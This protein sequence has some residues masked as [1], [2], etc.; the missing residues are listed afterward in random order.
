MNVVVNNNL[1]GAGVSCADFDLDGWEDL[2]VA[3][4]TSQVFYRNVYGTPQLLTSP[5]SADVKPKHPV[6]VDYDN[7][8]DLDYYFSQYMHPC[9]LFRNEGNW[10]FTDVSVAAGIEPNPVPHF[11][12]SWGDYDRDGDLDLFQCT[13][14]FIYTGQNPQAYYNK[15]YRNNGDGT[16]SE[17]GESAGVSDGISLSFQS[18]WMDYNNDGWPDLYVINDKF[19]PNRLYHNNGNGTFTDVGASSGAAVAEIDAMT[20]SAADYNGDGWEDIFITNTSIGACAL[21]TNNGDGTFTDDAASS[22]LE[23]DI[24][25]WAGNWFDFDLDMDQDLYVCE[26]NPLQPSTPNKFM[27]NM[28][29]GTFYNLQNFIFPLDFTNSYASASCDWNHDGYPDLAVNNYFPHASYF[30]KNSGGDHH[31]LQ[32]GLEGVVSNRMGVGARLALHAGGVTQHRYV[33]CGENYLGQNSQYELFGTGDE[34]VVD[35]L[36]VHWPSGHTDRFDGIATDQHVTVVE[37]SGFSAAIA[38]PD[39]L[40]LCEGDSLLL[41]TAVAGN[42]TWSNGGNTPAIWVTEAGQYWLTVISPLGFVSDSAFVEVIPADGQAMLITAIPETCHNASDGFIVLESDAEVTALLN[43]DPFTGE[44]LGLSHGDYALEVWDANGCLHHYAIVLEEASALFAEFSVSPVLCHGTATGQVEIVATNAGEFQLLWDGNWEDQV[45]NPLASGSYDWQLLTPGG[46][47][48]TGM[49]TVPEPD[50]LSLAADVVGVSCQGA[51]D[52]IVSLVAEGGTA[53]YTFS[54]APM[55]GLSAGQYTYNVVDVNGCTAALDV[56]ISEPSLLE[57]SIN[58]DGCNSWFVT[59]SGGTAPYTYQWTDAEGNI[60]S[61]NAYLEGI[62][63]WYELQLVVE[64]ARGCVEVSP[65]L[66]CL[67]VDEQRIGGLLYP[68]PATTWLRVPDDCGSGP[69]TVLDMSGR[70]LGQCRWEAETLLL[71]ILTDGLYAV[72]CAGGRSYFFMVTQ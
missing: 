43:G 56:S 33:Y 46:C 23:L 1:Y 4:D 35:S 59:V 71:P 65:W 50:A 17:V 20:A 11:G 9:K 36:I 58:T 25:G 3:L 30:W 67:S 7:D 69:W 19:H 16:F 32:V 53:P 72:H 2:V 70:V 66:Y 39:G 5:F 34:T 37:G 8:G 22:N 21:L 15:L 49:L 62:Q 38:A 41:Q 52:G 29:G 63:P 27:V 61:E 51:S 47:T 31:Y 24:L 40:V 54:T 13:Y 28:G 64:D 10:V 57:V 18:I 55:E 12:C 42:C 6:W 48:L 44:A 45:P 60:V 68:N 14:I 26:Y